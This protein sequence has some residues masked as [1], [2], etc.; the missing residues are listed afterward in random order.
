MTR[1]ELWLKRRL[2]WLDKLERGEV[3]A[4]LNE[5]DFTANLPKPLPRKEAFAYYNAKLAKYWGSKMGEFDKE[6][7]RLEKLPKH[8]YGSIKLST[9]LE[10]LRAAYELGK[11][12]AKNKE[13]L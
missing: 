2:E 13:A 4:D 7:E 9:F 3:K 6:V 11:V 5:L 10:A 1:G 12:T 8:K